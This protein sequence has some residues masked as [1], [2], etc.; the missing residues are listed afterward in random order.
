MG[1]KRGSSRG[2]RLGGPCFVP[3]H[4]IVLRSKLHCLIQE[5]IFSGRKIEGPDGRPK[6]GVQKWIRKGSNRGSSFCTDTEVTSMVCLLLAMTLVTSFI[7]TCLL[8]KHSV[9]C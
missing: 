7:L 3:N 2:S 5:P 6:K 9:L 4:F 8:Y 1:S